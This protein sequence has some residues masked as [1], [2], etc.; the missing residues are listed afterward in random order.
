M[1]LGE[2]QLEAHVGVH[3]GIRHVV[4]D[5]ARRPP[6]V[7]VGGVEL[8]VGEAL[9]R[10]AHGG[11]KVADGV[12]MLRPA[13]G[14]QGQGRGLEGADGVAGVVHGISVEDRG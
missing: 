6:A 10:L 9:H 7:A 12:D 8:R 14:R 2:R 3:V 11:G 5:L 4:H 1:L 13:L